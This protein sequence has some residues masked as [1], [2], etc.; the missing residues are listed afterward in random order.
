MDMDAWALVS[1][2]A[3]SSSYS[4]PML[5]N[6]LEGRLVTSAFSSWTNNLFCYVATGGIV[7]GGGSSS[8]SE[9]GSSSASNT[10]T[11]VVTILSKV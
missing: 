9:P 11:F 5:P 10:T 1:F 8:S 7:C 6:L 3:L 2:V 4:L